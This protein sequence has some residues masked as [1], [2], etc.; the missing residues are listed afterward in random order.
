VLLAS[1]LFGRRSVANRRLL[2]SI[3]RASGSTAARESGADRA[4]LRASKWRFQ[5]A[6]TRY[7]VTVK[8]QRRLS[9]GVLDP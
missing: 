1:A 2:P 9:F 3:T 7:D 8:L 4:H 5:V 6:A